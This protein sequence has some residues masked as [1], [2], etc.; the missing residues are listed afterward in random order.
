MEKSLAIKFKLEAN[1]FQVKVF[2]GKKYF[3]KY[4]PDIFSH[5]PEKGKKFLLA[6]FIYAR[7]RSLAL[8]ADYFLNY[9]TAKPYLKNFIDWG[10]TGD[11]GRIADLND[12]P[13]EALLK[14]FRSSQ[15]N[16]A[17]AAGQSVSRLPI[18]NRSLANQAIVAMS[19][20]KDSL[21]SYGLAK[22]IGLK[23]TLAADLDKQ[24]YT[25]TAWQHRT[26]IFNSFQ[27]QEQQKLHGFYDN[28]DT[29]LVNHRIA[30]PLDDL[31]GL[32]G[33]LAFYLEFMPMAYHFRTQY[34]IFGNEQNLNDCYI[35]KSGYK[36]YP[37]F[38]QSSAYVK[39]FNQHLGKLT[40]NKLQIVSLVEPLY[41]LAEMKILF[42]RYPHLAKYIM[43]CYPRQIYPGRWCHHCAMCA[44][45]FLYAAASGGDPKTMKMARPMFSAKDREF[46]PLFAKTITRPYEKPV[47]V[48]E[49]QLLAF[50]L[51]YQNG[52]RGY[53]MDLFAKK[54][55]AAAKRKEKFLRQKFFGLHPAPNLPVNIKN[56][57]LTIYHQELD[58]LA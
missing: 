48:R 50:L 8:Q 7:T 20:G 16:L 9:Q 26:A 36:S 40:G 30:K 56:K 33:M 55:L 42:G 54:Y 57:V 22:E 38:D 11:L 43:S 49:E 3:I 18:F 35:N 47:A 39:K 31:E 29:L 23:L 44:K 19:F 24:N 32:N 51:A 37:S 41:N 21:L 1:G 12:L 46:Y 10:I 53:L 25:A 28:V 58:N 27:L 52:W 5:F 2:S 6:N 14:K 45:A 4:P 17:F 13:T 15:N 34:L